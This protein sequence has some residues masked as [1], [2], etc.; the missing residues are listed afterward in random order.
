MSVAQVNNRTIGKCLDLLA[1][2]TVQII[3]LLTE[4]QNVTRMSR[5]NK[6]IIININTSK[7]MCEVKVKLS[8]NSQNSLVCSTKVPMTE[9]S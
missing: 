8:I 4:K 6:Y 3:L 9:V 2:K 7:K 5:D 1:V